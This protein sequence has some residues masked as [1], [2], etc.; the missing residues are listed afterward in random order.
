MSKAE[1]R[2]LGSRSKARESD[3]DCLCLISGG[4]D[5]KFALRLLSFLINGPRRSFSF[6]FDVSR[7]VGSESDDFQRHKG[8]LASSEASIRAEFF[9]LPL[10][11]GL[12]IKNRVFLS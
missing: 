7:S 6:V 9:F 11:G 8:N 1:P 5:G 2:W 4:N 10:D 12:A 3:D